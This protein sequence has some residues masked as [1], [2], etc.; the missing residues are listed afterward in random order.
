MSK[1]LD[2]L[3]Q[4]LHRLDTPIAIGV[5]GGVDSTF[6]LLQSL[7]V[8]GRGGV[9]PV[10][11]DSE[12]VSQEDR[13]WIEKISSQLGVHIESIRWEPLSYLE[14]R[15]NTRRRCY[16]CK[17]YMYMKLKKR[18][19][20]VAVHH[21]LD[22]TQYDD[23]KKDRPGLNAIKK[24]NILTPLADFFLTKEEI[25]CESNKYRLVT[26]DRP[27]QACLATKIEF[28]STLTKGR[29]LDAEARMASHENRGR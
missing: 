29:L 11:M 8:K 9:I 4:F 6:L 1:K 18:M 27:S 16:W 25:R 2:A 19:D 15:S 20:G 13:L 14:V 22:G 12:F 3:R 23:L 17:L 10:F 26:A 5:S 21:I 24:L 7:E 28:G